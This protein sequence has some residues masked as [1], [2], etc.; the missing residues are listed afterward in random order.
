[1]KRINDPK[2]LRYYVDKHNILDIFNDE[3]Y[4]HLQIH[5]F[6]KNEFVLL[7]E[8]D[9]DYYYLL[10]KGKIKITYSF[11]NGKT[12]LLEFYNDFN[13]LGDLELLHNTPVQCNVE[14][15]E[16][17]HLIGIPTKVLR[18][19]YLDNPRFL[20]HMINSLSEKMFATFNN[21]SYNLIYPLIN[22]L[23][24]YLIEYIVDDKNYI[25]LNSSY[26]EISEFLGTTYR[27]LSRTL[28]RLENEGI[29]KIEKK[30]I[31]ILNED[32]LRRLS[33]SI[34]ISED[35]ENT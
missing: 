15:I 8:D 30:K 19:G 2:L 10:V 20:K 21:T 5:E 33:K 11:E 6:E 4:E 35:R 26:K 18:E 28:K 23:A 1:M 3:I 29:L 16:A 24:S 7:S 25:V 32:G 34:Y 22:R 12:V 31:Y 27:H 9:L 13:S 17:C 14:V